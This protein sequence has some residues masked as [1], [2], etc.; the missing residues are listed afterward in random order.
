MSKAD[1][2]ESETKT[3]DAFVMNDNDSD[4]TDFNTNA[5]LKESEAKIEKLTVLLAKL[6]KALENQTNKTNEKV[7]VFELELDATM[8]P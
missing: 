6:K 4:K 5:A 1:N 3:E 7:N 8:L 2:I